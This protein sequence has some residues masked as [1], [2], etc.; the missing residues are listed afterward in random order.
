MIKRKDVPLKIELFSDGEDSKFRVHSEKE[1]QLIL[2]GIAQKG[3]RSALY[4]GSGNDF[5]LTTVLDLDKQGIW[6][7]IGPNDVDNQRILHSDKIVFVSSQHQVKVQFVAYRIARTQFENRD[8]FYLPLPDSLLR[9]QRREY[10][11]LL[12]PAVEPLKCVITDMQPPAPDP[13]HSMK[14]IEVTIMD[15]SVGGV[16]LVCAEHEAELQP[17]KIYTDC[18]IT[19]PEIGVLTATIRVKNTF[20]VTTREGAVKR[21]AGCE[22][23]QMDG[24]M[25]I[26]LQRYIT[27][28][29]RSN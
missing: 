22:F 15:I 25:A 23:M 1:I 13:E 5:I 3:T 11:R 10:F 14:K 20:E 9:I 8:A 19:L 18:E 16:S 6:L 7:D 29:Q 17:G 28:L 4:F 21:R 12:A 24:K 27:H 26:L 2:R